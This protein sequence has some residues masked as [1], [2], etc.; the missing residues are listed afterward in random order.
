[1]PQAASFLPCSPFQILDFIFLSLIVP[2]LIILNLIILESIILRQIIL[3]LA[4]VVSRKIKQFIHRTNA[5]L[6]FLMDKGKWP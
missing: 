6:L 5:E 2:D 1:M 3:V 4:T